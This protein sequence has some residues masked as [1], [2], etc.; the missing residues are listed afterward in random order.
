M[1]ALAAVPRETPEAGTHLA[2]LPLSAIDVGEN[3]RVNIADLDELAASIQEHGVLQPIKVRPAGDRYLVLWGQR[4]FLAAKQVGLE[5]IPALVDVDEAREPAT[6]AIEQLVENLHRADLPALDRARAMRA[7][8]DAGTSQADL[9]RELG[10]HAS[11]IANDLGLLEAPREIQKLIEDEV[12][13]PS[14]AK[15]LKGLPAKT[16]V[17]VARRVV[18]RGLSAHE[19]EQAVQAQKRHEEW[20]AESRRRTSAERKAAKERLEAGIAKLVA[21]ASRSAPIRV[22]GYGEQGSVVE[23]IRSAGFKDVKA[24]SYYGDEGVA[25]RAETQCDCPAWRIEAV[26]SGALTISEGCIVKAHQEAVLAKGRAGEEAKTKLV[27]AAQAYVKEMLR[28]S[29]YAVPRHARQALL[30][31]AMD[32]TALEWLKEQ[33]KA[34]KERKLDPW[35]AMSRLSDDELNTM[36]VDHASRQFHDRYGLHLDWTAVGVD[37]GIVEP[38][39]EPPAPAKSKSKAPK[40]S[41]SQAAAAVAE[42][43]ADR[44]T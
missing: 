9:A 30:W 29:V 39:P 7:V 8:V 11:T 37:L 22:V 14:H 20:E 23:A 44:L 27:T 26:Y 31:H 33:R 42:L 34:T 12:L 6:I 21:K 2:L 13:T 43:D 28:I 5:T 3:V 1:S 17:E 10:L 40:F 18:D 4:R 38:S 25:K 16:Q 41:A 15:A 24:V 35:A 19:T 32:Y 36:L